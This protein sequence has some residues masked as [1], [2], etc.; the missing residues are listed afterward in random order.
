[1]A[2][3]W[4]C[5][6]PWEQFFC[7]CSALG[8]V[9]GTRKKKDRRIDWVGSNYVLGHNLSLGLKAEAED[10]GLSA[11]LRSLVVPQKGGRRIDW[12]MH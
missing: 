6:R 4:R 10:L 11:D 9:T 3:C 1:M 7:F 12:L 2:D 8:F 5:S